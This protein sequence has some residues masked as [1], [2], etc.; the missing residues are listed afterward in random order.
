MTRTP[1]VRWSVALKLKILQENQDSL[2]LERERIR[3]NRNALQASVSHIYFITHFPFNKESVTTVVGLKEKIRIIRNQPISI[4]GNIFGPKDFDVA[5]IVNFFNSLP[6][7]PHQACIELRKPSVPGEVETF[8]PHEPRNP[9]GGDG[10]GEEEEEEEISTDMTITGQ[11]FFAINSLRVS[12]KESGF[13]SPL[14]L[15]L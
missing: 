5:P 10:Q 8:L 1:P 6:Q 4:E 2:L 13:T 12:L 7:N 3:F 15:I 14:E 9:Q 11:S